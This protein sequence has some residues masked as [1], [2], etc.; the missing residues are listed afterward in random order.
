M[1]TRSFVSFVSA[2]TLCV[3]ACSSTSATEVAGQDEAPLTANI[4]KDYGSFVIQTTVD[5]RGNNQNVVMSPAG[6]WYFSVNISGAFPN[7]TTRP[8]TGGTTPAQS[9]IGVSFRTWTYDPPFRTGDEPRYSGPTGTLNFTTLAP[10]IDTDTVSRVTAFLYK[11]VPQS[12]S[13]NSGGCDVPDTLRGVMDCSDIGK[14]CDVHDQCYFDN[15]CSAASWRTSQGWACDKC[16]RNAVNCMLNRPTPG[17]E[18]YDDH[19]PSACCAAGNCGKPTCA[20]VNN[21]PVDC[22]AAACQFVP[23]GNP[24]DDTCAKHCGD[25]GGPWIGAING[26]TYAFCCPK[27]SSAVADHGFTVCR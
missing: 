5:I 3:A 12:G 2:A 13:F 23:K 17:G 15:H 9:A 11:N 24:A 10:T 18:T 1:L 7:I 6:Q 14:C 19:G 22:V 4:L 20:M 16:N 25:F 26:T 8:T 21:Y 27:G